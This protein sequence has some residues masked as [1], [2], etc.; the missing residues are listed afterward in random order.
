[1]HFLLDKQNHEFGNQTTEMHLFA[2]ENQT[3]TG[4]WL[5]GVEPWKSLKGQE[6]L[7]LKNLQVKNPRTKS[8]IFVME[9]IFCTK[10]RYSKNQRNGF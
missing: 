1:M 10:V 5:F 9:N 7:P 4:T 2:T 8:P 6:N 3:Y